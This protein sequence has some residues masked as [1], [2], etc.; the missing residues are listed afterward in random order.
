[1]SVVLLV[2]TVFLSSSG[3]LIS[4][5]PRTSKPIELLLLQFVHLTSKS[6]GHPNIRSQRRGARRS[7]SG[8]VLVLYIDATSVVQ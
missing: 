3:G 1:M 7:M 2:G 4:V 5:G 6:I 8:G